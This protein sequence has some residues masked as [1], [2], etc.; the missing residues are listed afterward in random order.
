VCINPYRAITAAARATLHA[1]RMTTS[2]AP[3]TPLAL[4]DL[5]IRDLASLA[6]YEA[7]MALQDDIWG[8]GFAE[9]VPGAILRVSQKVGGVTAGAFDANQRLVGFVFGMTGVKDRTLVHWS[10]MLAVRP[11]ARGLGLGDALKRHQRDA[12]RALG[13]RLMLWT[14]D[15]LV[16]RNAHFN[17]NHL[18]AFPREYV[19]NMYGANTGSV[20]HGAMPTDRFVYHWTLDATTEHHAGHPADGDHA[21]PEAIALEHDGTPIAVA[22]MDAPHLRVPVPHD[23]VAVQAAS[24]AHALAWRIAVRAAFRRLHDGYRVSRFVRGAG[25]ALP[26]YVLSAPR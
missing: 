25:D 8:R 24:S 7:C 11:E 15:P 3:T 19:E 5:T 18:G 14:A 1:S 6:D 17:I 21:L 22:V 16:A 12:V 4:R 20:L 10:D 26:Y 23:L 2:T 9:R 13:V